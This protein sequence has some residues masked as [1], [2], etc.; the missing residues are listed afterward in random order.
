MLDAVVLVPFQPPS[1]SW[2]DPN[3]RGS[4]AAS[5][6]VAIRARDRFLEY[7]GPPFATEEFARSRESL[8]HRSL[9]AVVLATS[10]EQAGLTWRVVDPGSESLSAWRARLETLRAQQPR[11]VA[12]SST[13]IVDGLWL[14]SFCTMVRRLLPKARLAVGG[15]AYATD[16][17]KFL[18]LDADVLCIGEG[19]VRLVDIVR[20]VRD[21]R[22][23]EDIPGLYLRDARGKLRYTGD[24]EPLRLD[25]LPLP[26]W[27]LSARIEP[28][29][30]IDRE[31]VRYTLETQ[32]GC[33][34][35]CA[36]C[37]YRTL[38]A[39][40]QGSIERAVAAIRGVAARGHGEVYLADATATF[41]HDRWRLL[42]HRLIEEG[43]SPLP[44]TLFARVS[45][46]DD[47]VCAL[48]RR[49]GVRYVQVGQE[50][51]DQG[52]LNAMRKGTRVD[53]VA[54]AVAALARHEILADFLFIYGFPGE[55]EASMAATRR[56][57]L[58]LNDG[59]ESWPVV[60]TARIELFAAQDFASVSQQETFSGE[61]RRL[62]WGHMAVSPERAAEEMLLT[63]VAM[64][65]VPH[66]PAT[67]F[68]VNEAAWHAFGQQ[69][70]AD[71]GLWFFRWAKAFDRGI[72]AFVEADVAG[73]PLD[74]ALLRSLREEILAPFPKGQ[75][76]GG[77]VRGLR[78][79]VAH[80]IV[81]RVA[82]E[83]ASE[84]SEG[85]GPFTRTAVARE[86]WRS[87]HSLALTLTAMR[88]GQYPRATVDASSAALAGA[89]QAQAEQL[90]QLAVATGK[91]KLLRA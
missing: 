27:S 83:R 76:R 73:R 67:A 19:E 65:R 14:A 75:P 20:A 40:V 90:V 71:A 25:E 41:P 17:R 59:H 69:V 51:G 18:A 55:T 11:L 24:V 23:L 5:K 2:I 49:A 80:R 35:K 26:N 57:L 8:A 62:G 82:A 30:D 84:P 34:F 66:A 36:F 31:P 86:V 50:S 58:T 78:S 88:T 10:L 6:L 1:A 15:Y 46:L 87:T 21:G 45:D 33:V 91:R 48:M 16:A 28:P 12:L 77:L 13:F 7:L 63:Y 44:V 42:L 60:R 61:D 70:G 29:V 81:W 56:M 89:R 4:I 43:G 68:Q 9:T 39:P 22:G 85:V 54:P 32:R 74:A 72:G 52:V 38:A 47:D 3:M 53:R 79:R 37:T 64:S